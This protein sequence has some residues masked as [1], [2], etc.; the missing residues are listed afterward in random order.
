M[1][2]GVEGVVPAVK[3]VALFVPMAVVLFEYVLLRAAGRGASGPRRLTTLAEITAFA[4]AATLFTATTNS[5]SYAYSRWGLSGAAVAIVA[6]FVLIPTVF[7][8]GGSVLA[9]H[10]PPPLATDDVS[11]KVQAYARRVLAATAGGAL[12]FLCGYALLVAV[13]LA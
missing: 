10:V 13:Y 2:P 12:I 9:I 11:V 1:P 7:Q 3:D 5:G 6:Y 4:A 8:V